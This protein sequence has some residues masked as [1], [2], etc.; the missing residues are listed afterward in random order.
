MKGMDQQARAVTSGLWP[1]Y[2]YNPELSDQG[3]NPFKLDSKEPASDIEEYVY[4]E[5]R[6]KALRSSNPE[7]A[8]ELLGKIKKDVNHKWKE[9]KYLADR[10][11]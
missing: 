1:L 5:V 3:K 2:R 6:Y 11:F 7:R 10:P 4:N 8:E 9:Y